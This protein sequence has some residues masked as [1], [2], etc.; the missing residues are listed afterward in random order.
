MPS[1]QRAQPYEQST[2][3]QHLALHSVPTV[4]TT[5]IDDAHLRVT[6]PPA[7]TQRRTAHHG[8]SAQSM[9]HGAHWNSPGFPGTPLHISNEADDPQYT[10]LTLARTWPS[11]PTQLQVPAR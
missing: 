9:D 6:S 5:T 4:T 1:H 7:S 2:T 10:T 3:R 8:D 11:E